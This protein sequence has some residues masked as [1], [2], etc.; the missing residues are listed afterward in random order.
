MNNKQVTLDIWHQAD[1]KIETGDVVSTTTSEF[2]YNG[3]TGNFETT[4][5]YTTV[6]CEKVGED[7]TNYDPSKC[8][9]GGAYGFD[10]YEV[11]EILPRY[12]TVTITSNNGLIIG[13][14]K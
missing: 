1:E 3:Y 2:D 5:T 8:R 13:V 7:Y 10:Y 4:E 14:D 9:N 11:I 6:I 12:V